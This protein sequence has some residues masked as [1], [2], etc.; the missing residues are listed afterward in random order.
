[1]TQTP[2]QHVASQ[3]V[4][5]V[6]V[7]IDVAKDK[8]DLAR[9]DSRELLTVANDTAG[10][11]R[12]VD[13]LKAA[14]PRCIVI[15]ATGG[16]ETPLADALLEAQL[17][18]A[19]VNPGRVRHLAMG[20]GILAKSDPIDAFVLREFARL[21]EP[22]LAQKRSA[23]QAELD[24][25]VSCR[26]QLI[27][28]RTAQGNCRLT[29]RSKN[30]LKSI[31]TVLKTLDRQIEVLDGKIRQLINSDDDF[32]NLDRL[33]RSVPGVG[34][35]LS[36][37]LVAELGELGKTDRRQIGALVGVAPFNHDS[38]NYKGKRAVRGGRAQVRNV[39]Y[40]SALAAIRFNPVLKTFADR[41][42]QAGKVPKVVI[43]A[44][45]RKLMA[46]LN[47]MVRDNLL[48]NQLA[49]V[50]NATPIGGGAK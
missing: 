33:L 44:C 50:R 9:S 27:C 7:G 10:I 29:T 46:L 38:G 22:R 20:L 23:N 19:V 42:R 31:D 3:V 32:N 17:P 2:S 4:S 35:V 40:M 21:A 34:P 28:T 41:L 37:T 12:L 30:A 6:F 5:P 11:G 24:A 8:L 1:M 48:W 25:L 49:V 15:E 26:R 18:V 43:V 47:A 36:S 39:L 16:L 45:M 14:S 13:L